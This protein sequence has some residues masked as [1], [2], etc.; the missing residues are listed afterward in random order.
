MVD[1]FGG[2]ALVGRVDS[3]PE[4]RVQVRPTECSRR[5][6]GGHRGEGII[7]GIGEVGG[8]GDAKAT[9]DRV[10]R[11]KAEASRRVMGMEVGVQGVGEG[12]ALGAVEEDEHR[13]GDGK[14]RKAGGLAQ[15]K[16][17][18]YGGDALRVRGE[19]EDPTVVGVRGGRRSDERRR[20]WGVRIGREWR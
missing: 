7:N 16:G 18:L 14:S 10:V 13:L 3:S 2:D 5:H 12:G 6:P 15:A 11:D 4:A 17:S 8:E 19:D 9:R 1:R 20:S